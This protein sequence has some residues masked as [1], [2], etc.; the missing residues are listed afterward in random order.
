MDDNR[1]RLAEIL[2]QRGSH[3][4]PFQNNADFSQAFKRMWRNATA[5]RK[6]L[7]PVLEEGMDQI[8]MKISRIA[9]GDPYYVD[10]WDDIAGYATLVANH[11]RK[12][13]EIET[14]AQKIGR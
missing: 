13:I 5:E 8:I 11:L 6:G 10:N 2:Q 1:T 14:T 3:Y 4:G 9:T 12:G 7:H